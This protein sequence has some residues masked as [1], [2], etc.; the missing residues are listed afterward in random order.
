MQ[1]AQKNR[2]QGIYNSLEKVRKNRNQGIYNSLEKSKTGI[3]VYTT[4][5]KKQVF[6]HAQLTHKK[7][8][9]WRAYNIV[10]SK[11][12]GA[13]HAEYQWRRWTSKHWCIKCWRQN[14][15]TI[16][17]RYWAH[18]SGIRKEV[19]CTGL[20]MFSVLVTWRQFVRILMKLYANHALYSKNTKPLLHTATDAIITS[21][22][23]TGKAGR[24]SQDQ[25]TCQQSSS[26]RFYKKSANIKDAVYKHLGGLHV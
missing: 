15:S 5:S 6:V 11:Y 26:K 19:V 14:V 22:R 21:V 2:Y 12:G 3:R 18:Y 24:F 9:C 13:Q 10:H 1:L 4:H 16:W 25:S 23:S 8:K 17:T 7:C 20:C